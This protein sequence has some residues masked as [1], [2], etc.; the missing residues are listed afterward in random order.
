M[1]IG[2]TPHRANQADGITK[3]SVVGEVHVNLT[4]GDF[5]LAF[6]A[7]VVKDLDCAILGGGPFLKYN[8][9]TID[10]PNDTITI[11]NKETIIYTTAQNCS[12]VR[13]SNVLRSPRNQIIYP[14]DFLELSANVPDQIPIAI[15]PR[16]ESTWIQP[17]ISTAV[18]GHVRIPNLTHDIVQ[19]QKCGHIA[20][21][22]FTS[23]CE[24]LDPGNTTTPPIQSKQDI[25]EHSIHVSVDHANPYYND[26]LALHSRYDNVFNSKIGKYNDASGRIRASIN[27]GAIEPPPQKARLPSYDTNKMK[28]LQQKMDELGEIGVLAKPEDVNVK[29]EYV[30]PS[31]LV[32]KPDGSHR[33]VTAFNAVASYA[34]P[35]PSKSSSTDDVLCF[36][37]AHQFIIKTDMTK[38]FFQLPMEKSS[39]KYLG[40]LTPFK[41]LRVY[42][43]AAMGMPGSTEHLDE[44]MC[45]VLGDMMEAGQV[46]KLADD[47]YLGAATIKQL[48][49]N[50]EKVLRRFDENNLRLSATKTEICPVTTTI[51]GWVWSAGAIQASPHKVSPLISTPL[52]KTVKGLR[53][54]IGAYKH[55][56]V[57]IPQA[58]SHL[59]PL[60]KMV[61]GK[62]SKAHL[63]WSD[64]NVA[65]FHK[66]QAALGNLKCITIPCPD[67]K[68]VI[69]T[70][71]TVK[72]G[73][74]GAVLFIR[75]GEEMLLGGFF[76]ARMKT[77]QL[78]WLPC[79]VEALAISSAVHHWSA[80]IR[81][82]K[83]QTQ[84]LT[85][86]RPCVQAFKKLQ[87]GK[88]SHS[89]R[90]STFLS[91]LAQYSVSVHHISGSSNLPA[92]Y[93]SRSAVSCSDQMCQICQFI[94]DSEEV[95]VS[96]VQVADI[97]SGKC[98]IP[99]NSPAAWK[100]TQQDCPSLRRVYA[101]LTQGTRPNKKSKHIKDIKRYLKDCSIGRDGLLVVRREM[102]FAQTRDLTVVPRQVLPGLLS[103]LHLKL[104][105][106]SN[107]QLT[108]VFH[109]YFFALDVD[110][111]IENV[112]KQCDLCTSL[113]YLPREV[114]EFTTSD[115]LPALGTHFSC[116]IMR[117][118]GQFV[119]VLRDS[120]SSYTVS[121]ILPNERSDTVRG[122][123]I[124]CIAELKSPTGCI[125][126][127]DGAMSCLASDKE[128][129]SHNI[130]IEVGRLKNRNKNPQAEKAIQELEREI[131]TSHPDNRPLSPASL[132][133]ITSRLNSRVRNRGLSAR[134]IAFQR[135]GQTGEQLNITDKLLADDQHDHRVANHGPSAKCQSKVPI[136]AKRFDVSI[137]DLVYIKSEGDKHNSRHKYIV[138]AMDKDFLSVRKLI[139]SAFRSKLYKLRYTEI[140]PV[141]LQPDIRPPP[142]HASDSDSSES[143]MCKSDQENAPENQEDEI[144]SVQSEDE[145]EDE[146]DNLPIVNNPAVDM[147]VQNYVHP[148]RQRR[149]PAYL[150][151][152]AMDLKGLP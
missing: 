107:Y 58:G 124:E 48:L 110:H 152:Y 47:L 95:T 75:R 53:S 151:E 140:F 111:L 67:D 103:A 64:D 128:L 25:G 52:P 3:M 141:P 82:S 123:I 143:D 38:Q 83:Q 136:P 78:K 118:A 9:I 11:K 105:H 80:Y 130:I 79:E 22:H 56:A 139:G 149:P 96:S 39:M 91:T 147:Q 6:D 86:S 55:L 134:E 135:D 46:I 33:F 7:V 104:D 106:P 50:W 100:A 14:G 51:L 12:S 4:R 61:A 113:S 19:V 66:A 63:S 119:F 26:F 42:T 148:Q 27:M 59:S 89:A 120:F 132:A 144:S 117:R 102:P 20:Q 87:L 72:N 112:S 121:R 69:T 125:L 90:V 41:G 97:L 99:Y 115:T 45:R 114:E 23:T 29:V 36:L 74:I 76:S 138:V 31:F 62:D 60:D 129:L 94:V 131:K 35:V 142:S 2:P 101:H 24:N 116:D 17:Q 30:S 126:R 44:L 21:I 8:G 18:S 57:C 68:L 16:S 109:R 28:L 122:A 71:G 13:R 49:Q 98:P 65:A 88:F 40:V 145:E 10:M 34:K 54:W 1:P 5:V 15:E 77:H 84:L 137:G 92:D 108:K 127:G 81:E 73:G 133:V 37:A 32:N 93:Q 43:R 150:H 85:D 146:Q 70:D